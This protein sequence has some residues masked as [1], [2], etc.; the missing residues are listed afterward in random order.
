MHLTRQGGD[1]N[2]GTFTIESEDSFIEFYW[3]PI[4]KKQPLLSIVDQITDRIEKEHS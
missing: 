2:K 1:A 3:N 4:P